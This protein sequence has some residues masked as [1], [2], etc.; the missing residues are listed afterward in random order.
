VADLVTDDPELA[1]VLDQVPELSAPDRVVTTIEGG[2][3]NRNYRVRTGGG[4]YV[5]RISVR[6]TG[7]LGI[8]RANEHRSSV[9][10]WHAGVGV[11]VVTRVAEPEALVV[12]FVSGRTLEPADFAD[13]RRISVL[14]DL[15]R[16][17]HAC[18][19][20]AVDFDM[21]QVQRRYHKIV[22]QH[23]YPLP[24]DYARYATRGRRLADVLTSSRTRTTPCH[25]DLMPGNFI[26]EDGPGSRI[27]LIDYEYSGNN[28]PCYDLGDAINELLLEPER[29]EQLVTEYHGGPNARELARAQLW[30]LMS[31]Y[32]WSLWGAIRIGTTGDPEIR[33]WTRALWERAV[34]EFDSPEFDRLLERAVGTA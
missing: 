14:A 28:D 7:Q 10:A 20:F 3:T 24:S 6:E 32:G 23:G 27:W 13:P 8:D 15:L 30:S 21:A 25:N 34:A 17:L 2:L 18:E 22:V 4:D 1:R 11:G 16:R 29:A 5:V 33:E 31:K 9:L 26:E 12:Q 19:P